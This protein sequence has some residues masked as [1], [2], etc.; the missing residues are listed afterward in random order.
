VF[1]VL[2][3]VFLFSI[4]CMFYSLFFNLIIYSHITYKKRTIKKKH[5]CRIRKLDN[6]KIVLD[7]IHSNLPLI[8][9]ASLCLSVYTNLH[10]GFSL[11]LFFLLWE[12]MKMLYIWHFQSP[13]ICCCVT[14]FVF[15]LKSHFA[16]F[17]LQTLRF[18]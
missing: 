16:L 17:T 2:F 5:R 10:L 11:I 1:V 14:V 13:Q 4:L 15:L 7:F 12:W 18:S 9:F 3:C 8:V 6:V